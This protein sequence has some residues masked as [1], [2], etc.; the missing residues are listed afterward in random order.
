MA[1][2]T[3]FV[4]QDEYL[5]R[6]HRL[7]DEELGRLVR[8]LAAYHISGETPELGGAEGMAF[9]FIRPDIDRIEEQYRAKCE[10]NRRNRLSSD[11]ANAGDRNEKG[12]PSTTVPPR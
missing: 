2:M 9:D 7:T 3:G 12:R 5:S 8:A 6:L 11:G 10:T 1:R 4:F